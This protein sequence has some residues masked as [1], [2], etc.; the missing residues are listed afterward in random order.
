MDWIKHQTDD[1]TG[2]ARVDRCLPYVGKQ[3]TEEYI[4]LQKVFLV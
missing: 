4:E 1:S 3:A 2:V